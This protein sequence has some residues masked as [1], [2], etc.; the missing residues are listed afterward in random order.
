MT[1]IYIKL[2]KL[3]FSSIAQATQSSVTSTGTIKIMLLD[4]SVNTYE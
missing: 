1:L 3:M 2:L 4:A